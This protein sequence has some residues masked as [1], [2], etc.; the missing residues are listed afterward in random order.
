MIGELDL[1][2]PALWPL[3]RHSEREEPSELMPSRRDPG[4]STGPLQLSPPR[5]AHLEGVDDGEEAEA[6]AVQEGEGKER[7]QHE[8]FGLLLRC[9][10][11]G[12]AVA[13]GRPGP[14]FGV[15]GGHLESESLRSGGVHGWP[16]PGE[17]ASVE[18]RRRTLGWARFGRRKQ[19]CEEELK[20]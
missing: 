19:Y 3:L 16:R 4:P 6:A 2:G 11:A 1:P 12:R 15:V 13:G 5:R 17:V 14:P 20:C 7:A 8:V 18:P 10:E 9:C